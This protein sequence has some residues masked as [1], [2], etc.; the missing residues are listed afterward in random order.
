MTADEKITLWLAQ[1]RASGQAVVVARLVIAVAGAVAL[2]VPSV[3]SWDQ[4]D[5]VPIVGAASL[6]CTVVL[7][8]SLAAMMFVLV[9]T[10]GWLMRAP[11]VPSWSLALTSVALVVVHLAAAFAGQLPS[12]ARVHR[13]A[14]RR[15][16]LPGAIAVLLAPA[17]AG[18]AALVRGADV[19][20][21]L[22]VTVAAIALAA[23]TIWFAADQKLSRD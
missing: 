9:V 13:A 14:L 1:L 8:D 2:V 20:G 3:Q 7:P 21:S 10:L 23:A 11:G 6:L 22:V 12:Y 15:W 5:L 19:A 16:W 17:V 18:A 4:A